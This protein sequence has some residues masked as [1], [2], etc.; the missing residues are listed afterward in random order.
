MTA[1]ANVTQL[2]SIRVHAPTTKLRLTRRGRVV[3][4]GL[5][6]ILVS[7]AL[8]LAA[9]LGAT[10]AVAS[11][12]QN[13]QEFPYVLALP[14]D[15]LWSIATELDPAADPRAVVNDIVRLN[16]M[17]DSEIQAGEAF[18][19]PLRYADVNRVF[20]AAESEG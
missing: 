3:F 10:G 18:A 8:G 15:S 11:N 20:P 6:T 19:V 9:T 13:V 16:Q 5:A 14:G 4:G 7:V 2:E 17:P 1:L 12:S